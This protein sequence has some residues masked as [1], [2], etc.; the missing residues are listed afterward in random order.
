MNGIDAATFDSFP[1]SF[2]GLRKESLLE[3][4]LVFCRVLESLKINITTG[5]VLDVFRSLKHIDLSNKEDFY[6]TLRANLISN[7][8]EIALFDKA[9]WVFWLL[10]EKR[11]EI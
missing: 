9:F 11:K 5:R 8:Y 6:Y 1:Q 2:S 10:F 3:N 4:I 7:Y